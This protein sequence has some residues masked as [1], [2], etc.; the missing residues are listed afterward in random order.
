MDR[1]HW[2][3]DPTRGYRGRGWPAWIA[4]G[5]SGGLIALFGW[6]TL[7]VTSW[8]LQAFY[9]ALIFLNGW[10]ASRVWH[11]HRILDPEKLGQVAFCKLC[12]WCTVGSLSEVQARKALHAETEHGIVPD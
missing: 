5:M 10:T 4:V 9:L 1:L 6:T 2:S 8:G 12:G 3:I 7:G 11:T